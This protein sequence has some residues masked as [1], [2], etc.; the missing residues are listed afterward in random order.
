MEEKGKK[1]KTHFFEIYIS[2]VL[3][4]V[5][6]DCCI[7]SNAKQ[8]LNSFLCFLS[9]YLSKIIID[10]TIY[11]KK[12]TIS[13]KEIIN[14]LNLTVSGELLKN[15][16]IEGEKAVENF[17]NNT[18]KG[19]RQNKAEIL[20]PPSIV[21]KFLRNF[22]NS[23]IMLTSSA[24][25]FLSAALEYITYE[26]LDIAS[27][28]CTD[29]KRMRITIRDLE[30]V[31][32]TDIEL[33]NLF[34]KINISF[35]GGG[36][37]PFI[38]PTLLKKKK[39]K[40]LKNTKTQHRFRPGTVAIR[41]IKKYQKLSDNLIFA[42]SSFEKIIRN[43]FLQNSDNDANIKI[44]KNVFIIIQYYIEQYLV[45]LLYNSNFL[46][47]HSNRVKLLPI[48]IAFISYLNNDTK[49]P[50]NSSLTSEN[51]TNIFTTNNNTTGQ[52]ILSANN[53]LSL[54]N[55]DSEDNGEDSEDNEDNIYIGDED[56]NNLIEI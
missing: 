47:I 43:I 14:S 8:Q 21:E 29:N 18:K 56:S 7:T 45:K 32:R 24:P 35:L 31:V 2:K 22:G 20:F 44:S 17:K 19:T 54:N 48:D 46:A 12:K 6:E 10:L 53:L 50:Y 3:K 41:D 42:K 39:I 52:N 9:S 13:D 4:Q 28:Y 23:K 27:I 11:G 5:S 1:K 51:D 33:N 26:I 37:I 36:V 30:I 16:I 49:N 34:N 55:E 25:V 38:H 40:T 15:S